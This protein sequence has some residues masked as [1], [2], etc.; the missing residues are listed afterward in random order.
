M[1][2][3]KDLFY[4]WMEAVHCS[5]LNI[6][7]LISFKAW[8]KEAVF[9]FKASKAFKIQIGTS[10]QKSVT[11]SPLQT[12]LCNFCHPGCYMAFVAFKTSA[13]S[14]IGSLLWIIAEFTRVMALSN[15]C[16]KFTR[17]TNLMYKVFAMRLQE[18]RENHFEDWGHKGERDLWWEESGRQSIYS[19]AKIS[20]VSRTESL[21]MHINI[22]KILDTSYTWKINP[23][24]WNSMKSKFRCSFLH[25]TASVPDI[26]ENFARSQKR[27]P[28][29]SIWSSV[30]ILSPQTPT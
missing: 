11:L 15:T 29:V 1:F 18:S 14:F 16:D 13:L 20:K 9:H 22:F 7:K 24:H 21:K 28:Y 6:R 4:G 2:V 25:K 23:K 26:F 12:F 19:W 8:Q 27:A 30:S 17:W 3:T 5:N 10:W